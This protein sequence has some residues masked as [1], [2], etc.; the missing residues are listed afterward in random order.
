MSKPTFY[1]TTPIYYPSG[2]F[3]IGTAYTTVASDAM[4]RYKRARGFD[5]RF[6]TGMDEHGQKIQEKAQEAGKEPQAYVDEIADAAKKLWEMMDITND[7]FIRTTEKR[8]EEMVEKIFAKFMEN[9]DIY[10][11]H[12][13]GLYCTPCESYYTE[14]QLV[15]G[16]CPD[17]GREVKVVKEESYFFNMKKYADRLVEYYNANPEFILP[18]SRKNEM[19]NNF[20]KPGLED[21]SVSRTTFDWGVKVP[22][23]PKHVIYVWVDALSNYITALGYGS[24]NDELFNKY[25]P[26]D[27]HVVGKDIVRFHTIYWPIFLMALDLPL[28]KKIFAHGFIMMKD[29]KMSKSKGNVVYPEMLIERYGLDAVRYFLLRELPFGQDG[30]FSPE[31]FVERVNFDLANDL[32]NLLNRTVSMINKYFGGEIPAYAGQVTEFDQTLEDFIKTTVEKVEKNFEDM[33]FSIVLA[34]IWALVSG[35]K[36]YIDERAPWVLAKDEANKEKLASVMNHLAESLRQ[37]AIMIEPFMPRTTP[38]I[39]AQLGIEGEASKV[40]DSLTKFDTLAQGTKVVEKGTPIFPRLEVEVEVEYIK[41]QMSQSVKPTTEEPKKEEKI[42]E[43][44]T[45]PLIGIDDFMKVEIKVGQI[46][47]CKQHPKADRLLVSQIDLGSE[48]RQIVSG[49]AEHY[50]PE[51]LVGRKVLVVTNLKPVKLRGELSEGMVLAASNDGTLTLPTIIDE[52]PNGSKV[53]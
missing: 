5:V 27:V 34:D 36:K 7:D 10:K 52:L 16:K 17:C 18:E 44:E 26:A 29:G 51:Q 28:P 41:D 9:G 30:V 14:T 35:T 40:W 3:H 49:I 12:Y 45:T 38:Q 43:V 46:K 21:L 15:D 20:I 8:H 32:G 37:I 19:V 25:W 22:G 33:Q 42:E 1:I 24:D 4:A 13:E 31:S 50:Q 47:E 53:K 48:V 2:K 23:D 11:G 39:F 6:L